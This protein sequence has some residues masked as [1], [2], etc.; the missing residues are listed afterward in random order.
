[1]TGT[2]P[3]P[4]SYRSDAMSGGRWGAIRSVVLQVASLLTTAILT[5][6]LTNEEYGLVAVAVIVVTMFDLITRV[7]FGASIIRKE[8]LTVRFSSTFFWTS[9]TLGAVA[10]GLAFIAAGPA[11]SLAGSPE[12]SALVALAAVTL[13]LNLASRVPSAL[14]TRKFR[15]RA[16]AVIDVVSALA[17]GVVAVSLAVA[18]VGAM[19]VV[20]GQVVRSAVTLVGSTVVSGFRPRL[21]FDIGDVREEISFNANWLTADLV[22]YANKNADYWFVGNRLGAGQLG[23]YYVAYVIPTLLRRRITSIGH[24]VLYPVVSRMRDDTRRVVS[25]Y[26][27]VARLVAFLVVPAMLGLA[28][29]ADLAITIG[30][31]PDWQ[32]AT[33]P[34]R[35]IALA[36]AVTSV[37]VVANPIFP[38]LGR[39]GMLVRIG[40]V[41]LVALGLGLAVSTAM[42]TL[43][44]VAVA[45]LVAVVFEGVVTQMNLK[46]LIG[47]GHRRTL[48][49]IAPFVTSAIV[50]AG[51]VWG[52]RLMWLG[53]M[54]RPLQAIVLVVVGGGVYMT[55]GLL[56]FR[57]DFVEQISAARHLAVPGRSEKG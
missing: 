45:V 56:A 18:G 24:D 2:E 8:P 32:E 20:I 39:P 37:V 23:I 31:G 57:S 53:S 6:I 14:L 28:V 35:L 15:F 51:A 1:M 10:G 25:A 21:T 12:A 55:V 11:A 54:G 4:K 42:G 22:S 34:L 49:A 52:V 44:A 41:A 17:H 40:L 16:L 43:T 33:A 19:A 36:A 30:F 3:E 48:K 46:S 5:R 29:V 27:R 26:L 50:M 7:G 13:P 38:A 47:L 9:L